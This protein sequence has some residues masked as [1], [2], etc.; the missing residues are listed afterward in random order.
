MMP[1]PN[2]ADLLSIARAPEAPAVTDR[3]G[4]LSYAELAAQAQQV[5]DRLVAQGIALGD[6]VAVI[7]E[8]SCRRLPAAALRGL[9][10][11]LASAAV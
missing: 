5:A 6:R 8:S 3:A 2:I 11:T 9:A 4:T 10:N 7:V 1:S